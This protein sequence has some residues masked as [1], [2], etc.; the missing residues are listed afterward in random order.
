MED[1][2]QWIDVTA[3]GDSHEI[4]MNMR[5]GFYRHRRLDLNRFA[6][7]RHRD[8][9]DGGYVSIEEPWKSGRPEQQTNRPIQRSEYD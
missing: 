8:Q 4:Q 1:D 2:D 5:T 3:L 7:S 6:R 9:L